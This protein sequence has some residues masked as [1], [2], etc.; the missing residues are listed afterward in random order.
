[1][2]TLENDI[3]EFLKRYED[4]RID[5]EKTKKEEQEPTQ[6]C[7]NYGLDRFTRFSD[8]KGPCQVPKIFDML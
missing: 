7:S 8:L 6:T 5:K 4:F 3:E 2:E 1:M